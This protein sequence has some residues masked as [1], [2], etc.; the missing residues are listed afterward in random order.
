MALKDRIEKDNE[1]LFFNEKEHAEK[2]LIDGIERICVL[3]SNLTGD[4]TYK[5]G[6]GI[7]EGLQLA[8]RAKTVR[9]NVIGNYDISDKDMEFYYSKGIGE[10]LKVNGVSWRVK[11]K[12]KEG[13]VIYFKLEE[14]TAI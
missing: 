9:N 12:W 6:T 1:K 2:A 3:S 13:G 7:N 14:I 10:V 4:G 8:I 11:S 5:K